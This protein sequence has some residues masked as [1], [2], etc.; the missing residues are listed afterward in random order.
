MLTII[1]T[2]RLKIHNKFTCSQPICRVHL[3][4]ELYIKSNYF[5][6]NFQYFQNQVMKYIFLKR[7]KNVIVKGRYSRYSAENNMDGAA[8]IFFATDIIVRLIAPVSV[9]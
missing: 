7:L 1:Y 4:F 6:I 3:Y 5:I 8:K 9:K 2:E